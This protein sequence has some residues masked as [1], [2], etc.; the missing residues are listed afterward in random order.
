MAVNCSRLCGFQA[1]LI[2]HKRQ[3]APRA[4]QRIP[5]Q[6][7]RSRLRYTNLHVCISAAAT[8]T[9][10]PRPV[11]V[12]PPP[13]ARACFIQLNCWPPTLRPAF[14]SS[15]AFTLRPTQLTEFYVRK[16]IRR[17]RRLSTAD[18]A[19][20]HLEN[21]SPRATPAPPPAPPPAPAPAPAPADRGQLQR[22]VPLRARCGCVCEWQHA[23]AGLL[24]SEPRCAHGVE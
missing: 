5:A 4:S 10:S 8:A 14:L 23:G 22:G 9:A 13:G 15:H 2:G 1:S 18:L 6:H 12:A 24:A 19:A 20:W 16:P 3:A 21:R 11:E 7:L 17:P